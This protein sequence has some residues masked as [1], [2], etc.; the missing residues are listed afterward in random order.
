MSQCTTILNGMSRSCAAARRGAPTL[1]V[2]HAISETVHWVDFRE[3]SGEHPLFH[4]LLRGWLR[5]KPPPAKGKDA[6][7]GD[8]SQE[9][10][11]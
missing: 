10:K 3:I 5:E 4:H 11:R 7:G 6:H 9:G 8:E 2:L 1:S